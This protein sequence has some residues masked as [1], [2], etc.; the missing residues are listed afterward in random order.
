MDK[1]D[2]L[3][4]QLKWQ[5]E[6]KSAST[7]PGEPSVIPS[8]PPMMQMLS[9]VNLDSLDLVHM[10]CCYVIWCSKNE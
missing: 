4:H 6:L 7:R 1:L 2:S 5:E 9:V 3:V 8:G 10:R